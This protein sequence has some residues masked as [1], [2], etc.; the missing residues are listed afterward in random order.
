L[1]KLGFDVLYINKDR[2]DTRASSPGHR[3][4]K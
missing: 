3:E 2:D 4:V 1:S